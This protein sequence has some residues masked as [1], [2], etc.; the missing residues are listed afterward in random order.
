MPLETKEKVRW[1]QAGCEGE[2]VEYM[3]WGHVFE[4]EEEDQAI[5]Y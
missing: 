4:E 2:I 1:H 5:D 3:F